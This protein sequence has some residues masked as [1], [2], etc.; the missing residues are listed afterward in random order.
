MVLY[1]WSEVLLDSTKSAVTHY[2]THAHAWRMMDN[3][4]DC[5]SSAKFQRKECMVTII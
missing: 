1:P 5:D 4:G 2:L 3:F